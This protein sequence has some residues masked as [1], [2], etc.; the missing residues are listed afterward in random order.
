MQYIHNEALPSGSRSGF[1]AYTSKGNVIIY[2]QTVKKIKTMMILLVRVHTMGCWDDGHMTNYQKWPKTK[3]VGLH[4]N[5]LNMFE[6]CSK[7][8]QL[9]RYE[10]KDFSHHQLF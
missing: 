9:W 6:L 10:V 1:S 5:F 2:D 8:L 4:Y 7:V 3:V